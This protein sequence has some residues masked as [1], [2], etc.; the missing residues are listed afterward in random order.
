M[1]CCC[2]CS[3][4][5]ECEEEISSS[6]DSDCTIIPSNS[7]SESNDSLITACGDYEHLE[8]L[9][10]YMS[11]QTSSNESV[12]PEVPKPRP[13]SKR[14]RSFSE[15]MPG[16]PKSVF[17]PSGGIPVNGILPTLNQNFWRNTEY[18]DET[19]SA[20]SL[21]GRNPVPPVEPPVDPPVLPPVD[22]TSSLRLMTPSYSPAGVSG[23]NCINSQSAAAVSAGNRHDPAGV[24]FITQEQWDVAV[25]DGVTTFDPN[26][27]SGEQLYQAIWP[28]P[29]GPNI[30]AMLGL[31][32]LYEEKNPFADVLSPTVQEIEN[33][34][35]EV[36]KHLRVLL[37]YDPIHYPLV[38]DPEM[39]YK[40]HWAME[41]FRST[42]WDTSYPAN[43]TPYYGPCVGTTDSHCG[44]SFVPNCS[45]QVPYYLD[46]NQVCITNDG[47]LEGMFMSRNDHP[48]CVKLSIVL[49]G[50]V[51]SEHITGH[52]VPIL[53]RTKIGM[54]W[55]CMPD[56][57]VD[58]KMVYGGELGP[59]DPPVLPPVDP[60]VTLRQYVP[61]Y[62][63]GGVTGS[64][65]VNSATQIS[66][67]A[68]QRHDPDGITWLTPQNWVD[69]QWDGV[70]TYNPCTLSLTA[71]KAGLFPTVNTMR[72]LRELFY[73]TVPFVDNLAPTVA[74]IDN[75]NIIVLRHF[76]KLMGFTAE[77]NPVENDASLYYQAHWATERY[78]TTIWDERYPADETKPGTWGP[79]ALST[80]DHCGASFVPNCA[81]QVPYYIDPSQPCVSDTSFAEGIFSVNT[82]LPWC[83]K[84]ARTI[85]ITL[86]LDGTGGHT[87]PFITR[88]K[89]G[90]SWACGPTTSNL[91]AKWGGDSG[92]SCPL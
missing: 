76:R 3:V 27:M 89:M 23:Q 16:P 84:F 43:S 60:P 80:N 74:E 38:K 19:V 37:R 72:G 71:L 17:I 39:F 15:L 64:A 42:I 10:N 69:A 63:P 62:A 82:N 79:C 73:E 9:Y 77:S 55:S 49:A 83:I 45:D 54:S 35:V 30:K 14:A 34:N 81:D 22:P 87:G 66:V 1:S 20:V 31:R 24:T 67:A 6:S 36:I 5:L 78:K 44:A 33:W 92:P 52:M 50:L 56:G 65:C 57:H 21:L 51:R 25:W 75:W 8:L 61:D 18:E 53:S 11:Q 12:L 70:T 88:S 26:V 13:I 46:S 58:L 86:G 2:N 48:W 47:V 85:A 59:V 29:F 7:S 91:R 41:R 68:G 4:G 90:L 40:A 32:Q 28:N